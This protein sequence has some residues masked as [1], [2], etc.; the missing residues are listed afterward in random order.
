[1]ENLKRKRYGLLII[2]LTSLTLVTQLFATYARS[3]S[4]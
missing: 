4:E 3:L 1:M 2:T